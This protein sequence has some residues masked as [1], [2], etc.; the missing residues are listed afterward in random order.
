M[1]AA[2]DPAAM[3]AIARAYYDWRNRN[4]PVTS[5]DQGLHTWDDALSDPAGFPERRRHVEAVLAEVKALQT[6]GW[7]KD[8]RVDAVIL[9]P[10]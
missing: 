3:R 10:V 8:D 5:S 6:Q 2:S 7:N 9:S 1:L 4:D